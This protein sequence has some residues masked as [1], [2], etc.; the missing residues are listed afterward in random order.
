MTWRDNDGR[1]RLA[2]SLCGGRA[3]KIDLLDDYA[4]M[5]RAALALFEATGDAVYLTRA[6]AWAAL[7][8]GLFGDEGRG[9]YFFSPAAAADLI[10]R[11]RTAQDSAMP[12]GNGTMAANLAQLFYLT[13][14]A[15]ARDQ[16]DRT[17][18]A[19][20]AEAMRAF[21]HAAAL[22][23]GFE[24]LVNAVQAVIVG[25]AGAADVAEFRTARAQAAEPNLVILAVDDSAA[26][27]EGHPAAGKTRI[28]GRTAVYVC[29]G[30]SCSPP[31]TDVAGVRLLLGGAKE[32]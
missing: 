27:P 3:Q 25:E 20:D 12:S 32:A 26:L 9:G 8:K 18:K 5:I 22:L 23:N 14:K 10:V 16:A 7:A 11:S 21:P 6:E 2:H 15:D 31:V 1:E 30:Q 17:L 4:Q 29:R 13:G 24:L 28:A 19:F